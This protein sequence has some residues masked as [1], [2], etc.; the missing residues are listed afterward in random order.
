MKRFF[1]NDFKEFNKTVTD[2]FQNDPRNI[3]ELILIDDLKGV[4]Y[5]Y[6]HHTLSLNKKIKD[7]FFEIKGS[8]I[9]EIENIFPISEEKFNEILQFKCS[10]VR[11]YFKNN[12]LKLLNLEEFII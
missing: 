11:G 5:Y 9:N 6:N 12:F 10:F 3:Y 7:D 8:I 1:I 4:Y 2:E